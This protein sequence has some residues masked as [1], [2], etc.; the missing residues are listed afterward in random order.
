[1]ATIAIAKRSSVRSIRAFFYAL[2]LTVLLPA[3]GREQSI[4]IYLRDDV[5]TDYVAFLAGRSPLS[6]S[7]FSGKRV[8][9]DVVD[10][11]VA[12]QALRLGG[13]EYTFNYRVGKINFR[14]TRLLEQGKL[15]ISFDTYWRADA[16][17]LSEAVF[18]SDAVIRQGEYYAG[19]YSHPDNTRVQ[20]ITSLADMTALTA[21]STPRWRSDWRTLQALPLKRIIKEDEWLSQARMVSMQWVDFMLMPLMPQYNNH[22]QL[23]NISLKAHPHFVVQIKDSRHFVVS[24]NHPQGQ[25]AFKAL[26]KGLA[27]L[28]EQGRIRAAYEQAGFIPDLTQMAVLNSPLERQKSSPE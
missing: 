5:Y 14:N 23:D 19:I 1:M 17:I 9:R 27:K 13:F 22:Y 10:M 4:D 2:I 11:I 21:V 24:R 3:Q 8:R 16:L 18:V 26:Q 20:S 7:D 6:V 15:L 25:Q 12:Q 28:R